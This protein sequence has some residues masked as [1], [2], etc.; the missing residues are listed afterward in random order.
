MLLTLLLTTHVP[1]SHNQRHHCVNAA[2]CCCQWQECGFDGVEIHAGNGYLLQQFMATATNNR[3]DEYGGSVEGRCRLLLEVVDAV[4]AAVNYELTQVLSSN[5][6]QA[7]NQCK[8]CLL[9]DMF[10]SAAIMQG[11][12]GGCESVALAVALLHWQTLPTSSLQTASV[13]SATD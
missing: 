9:L 6:G 8:Y 2:G 3:D 5:I 10:S 11:M 1:K 7:A 12:L 4:A 13:E